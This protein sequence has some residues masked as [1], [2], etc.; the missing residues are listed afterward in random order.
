MVSPLGRV[1]WQ[2]DRPAKADVHESF[3]VRRIHKDFYYFEVAM[4]RHLVLLLFEAVLFDDLEGKLVC[5][6]HWIVIGV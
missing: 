2:L 3:G 6:A 4:H 1:A 5:L